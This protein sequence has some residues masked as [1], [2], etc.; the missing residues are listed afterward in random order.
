MSALQLMLSED[1]Q[2]TD[3]LQDELFQWFMWKR[4]KLLD[5]SQ[6]EI[7]FCGI[8]SRMYTGFFSNAFSFIAKV[9][10]IKGVPVVQIPQSYY[11]NTYGKKVVIPCSIVSDSTV[12]GIYWKKY[13]KNRVVRINNGD[14]GYQGISPTSPS[15][16]I[17]FA[18]SDDDGTY[19]CHAINAAGISTSNSATLRL[20]G[21]CLD[22]DISPTIANI[23]QGN[24]ITIKC[25][26]SGLPPATSIIWQFTPNG[27]NEHTSNI[28]DCDGK[29]TSGSLQNPSLTVTNFQSSDA[30]SYVCFATNA[31]GI[32]SSN[33]PSQLSYASLP[34]V[35]IPQNNYIDTYGK[36]VVIPCSIVSDSTVTG[37]YWEKYYKNEVVRINNGD[38]GYQGITPTSP[39]LIINFATSDDDGTY[40]CHA[41]N[42]AGKST[43]NSTTLR[44]NGGVL[45]VSISPISATIINGQ[46]QTINCIVTGKPPATSIIWEFTPNGDTHSLPILV[47]DSYGK[48]TGGSVHNPS[49]TITNFQP[50]DAGSYVCFA[51]NA[52][53]VSSCIIPSVFEYTGTDVEISKRIDGMRLSGKNCRKTALSYSLLVYTAMRGSLSL[54]EEHSIILQ[55]IAEAVFKVSD[56]IVS[57]LVDIIERKLLQIYLKRME[58]GT[59]Q[60][61]DD[62]VQKIIIRS[63]GNECIECLLKICSFDILFDHVRLRRENKDGD[64]LE[65]DAYTLA[66]AFFQRIQ[67]DKGDAYLIGRYIRKFGEEIDRETLDLFVDILRQGDGDITFYHMDNFLDGLTKEGTD[68]KVFRKFPTLYD[69]FYRTVDKYKN[70]LLHFIVAFYTGSKKYKLYIQHFCKNKFD[71]L[72]FCNCDNYT[73]IDFASFLRRTEV[74]EFVICNINVNRQ[75]MIN[76]ILETINIVVDESRI[77]N[78]G[79]IDNLFNIPVNDIARG[80]TTD[81]TNIMLLIGKESET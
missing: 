53:G 30:G 69:T 55:E 12:T 71:L 74:I 7:G 24:N 64:I 19:V 40:T 6:Y 46:N 68:F 14:K 61:R 48:Y 78:T 9:T 79:V 33:S 39:S 25:T 35:Q 11:T 72:Q 32:S 15:L 45:D 75:S 60:P 23:T 27:G 10:F 47:E 49:L 20:N 66:N 31:V 18:T 43:S 73:A 56:V 8:T 52:V 34:V 63:F 38:I 21:E 54:E 26:V 80:N 41:I 5:I 29:Y 81:Y 42:A 36:K 37:I 51:F 59:Y 4:S 57:P 62:A 16:I 77:L 17:N 76:R 13:Y 65:V 44:L 22:I 50:S 70:T 2:V 67:F 3:L 1:L 28:V 58:N